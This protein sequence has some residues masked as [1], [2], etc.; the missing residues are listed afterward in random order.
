MDP[1][2]CPAEHDPVALT[3]TVVV[4]L[5]LIISYL[6]QHLRIIMKGSSEGLSPWFLLLGSTS[7]AA[8]MLNVVALQWDVIKCCKYL[9]RGMCIENLGGVVQVIVQ[10]ILFSATLI[11]FLIYFPHHLKYAEIRTEPN[12]TQGNKS[13]TFRDTTAEWKLAVTLSTIVAAHVAFSTFV[14]LILITTKSSSL[15]LWTTFL[16]LSAAGLS[17]AQYLPQIKKTWDLKLVG[18]LSIV[19]MCIQSPGAV[20]MCTSIAIRPGT[21]WTSWLTYAAAGI[22]QGCLLVMCLFWK[23]RQRRLG[24]DDFGR[25]LDGIPATLHSAQDDETTPLLGD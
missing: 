9:S 4:T 2:S 24:I 13:L 17:S 15:P 12:P 20:L 18:S 19:T 23:R 6:P 8:G 10:W 16:G 7:C 3:L 1:G 22:L 25:P 21:N 11:L 14:T 5:G